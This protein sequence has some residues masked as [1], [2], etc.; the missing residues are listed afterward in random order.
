[1][2]RYQIEARGVV[3]HQDGR[4]VLW[5]DAPSDVTVETVLGRAG[6]DTIPE[7]VADAF[8]S[9]IDP[10]AARR[11]GVEHHQARCRDRAEARAE[12]TSEEERPCPPVWRVRVVV[13]C[14]PMT[15]AE[16]LAW[17]EARRGR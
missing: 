6:I 5:T 9:A 2:E 8:G 16:S 13:E 12:Y 11:D 10:Y 14:E 1:M 3:V 15:E 4:S 7:H 17:W